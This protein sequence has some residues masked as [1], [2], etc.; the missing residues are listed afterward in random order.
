MIVA[1]AA[2]ACAGAPAGSGGAPTDDDGTTWTA[3]PVPST[4]WTA[5]PDAAFPVSV[6]DDGRHVL[7]AAGR[8][9]VL[10]GD[11]G[12]SS[13]AMLTPDERDAYLDRL[14]EL[15]YDAVLV[16]VVENAFSD[17]PPQ[18]AA[19]RSPFV[20]GLFTSP[21]DPAY[22]AE[23]DAYVDAAA[24]RG[25]TVL[26]CIAY[27]GL[28]DADGVAAE[29]RDATDADA[30][31]YGEFVGERYRDAPNIVWVMGGDRTDV[32]PELLA[33]VDA[34]AEGV[35]A[36]G[37]GHL[38]TA[39]AADGVLGSDVY[40]DAAWL[41]IDTVYDVAGRFVDDTHRALATAPARPVLA[42]EGL[43]ENERDEPLAPGDP[44]LRYQAW[45]A[46]MAGAFGHVFGNNPRWHFG[47]D[48]W[49][50]PAPTTWERTLR[51]PDGTYDRSTIEQGVLGAVVAAWDWSSTVPD[52]DD[53]FVTASDG[54]HPAVARSGPGL[55]LVY[56][57][58]GATAT[59]DA[60]VLGPPPY[61]VTRIDPTD[62]ASEVV[63]V[64]DAGS[65]EIVLPVGE[66]HAMGGTDWVY[67]VTAG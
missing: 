57:P 48:G 44:Y 23:V 36:G 45:G 3:P 46:F 17:H 49:V 60:S 13:I 33:R 52:V 35:R 7:D 37:D 21:P 54:T 63:D 6:S 50:F 31:A 22:W 24:R 26:A 39:H 56:V 14:A 42:V 16:N 27:L 64:P 1:V 47:M 4:A 28:N 65:P 19:G 15:G 59:L 18:D 32:E 2:A 53:R 67:V 10:V 5:A 61:A 8:P 62:G 41:Q 9:W 30:A 29:L 25:I 66:A 40:G 51:D 38:M 11:A 20:D 34:M 43:Y 55:G 12:W 58:D